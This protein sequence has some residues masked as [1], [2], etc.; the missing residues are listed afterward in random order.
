MTQPFDLSTNLRDNRCLRCEW[1]EVIGFDENIHY[2]NDEKYLFLFELLDFV[3]STGDLDE[4]AAKRKKKSQSKVRTDCW[5]S[6][7]LF[8]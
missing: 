7:V 5:Q 3:H 8:M 1:D 2:F 4:G 6:K